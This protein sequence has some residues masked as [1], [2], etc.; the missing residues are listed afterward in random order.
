MCAREDIIVLVLVVVLVL[1]GGLFA[2]RY[3]TFADELCG[4]FFNPCEDKSG[5]IPVRESATSA[6]KQPFF[7]DEDDDED[8][9]DGAANTSL[10]P[11]SWI[12]A[13]SSWPYPVVR[14]PLAI[15]LIDTITSANSRSASAVA[16][17][18]IA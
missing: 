14:S 16:P 13:P 2:H 17:A 18:A 8:D 15:A 4:R 11:S 3:G 10:S 12:P 7:E 9:F 5:P 6:R 1:E